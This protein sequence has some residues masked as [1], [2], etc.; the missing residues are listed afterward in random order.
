[1]TV[2][3]KKLNDQV[4][5][6]TGATSGIGLVTART[7]AEAGAKLVL[8][9][10]DGDALD[11]LAHEMRQRGVEAVTVAADVGRM[12]DVE[13]IGQA[14]IEHFGRIDTWVNNAGIGVYGSQEQVSLEDMHRVMQTN[15]WGVVHG[16]LTAVKLMKAHGGGAIINVGSEAS[17]RSVPLMGTYAASKHAVKAFTESLRMELEKDEAPISLTLIKPAGIDTPFTAHA[18]NY[19]PHEPDLPPPVY[20]PELVA[21]T[22]LHAAETPERDL[23]VGGRAR[24]LSTL[25]GL[26]PRSVDR[27]M[28]ATVFRQEQQPDQPNNPDRRDALHAPDPARELRQRNNLPHRTS[29]TSVY[30]AFQMQS[31]PV[32]TVLVGGALLAAWGLMR[33]PGQRNVWQ[34]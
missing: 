34:A 14:A 30:T 28:R 21:K 4:M 20:A 18:K 3:L 13:R 5:V 9:A 27:L 25:S 7:A 2:K 32:K 1:M 24:L 33:R 10:R 26:M 6:L 12:D 29:E 31:A 23:F 17:D 15:F 19:M 11:T 8:A 22:I 16:S